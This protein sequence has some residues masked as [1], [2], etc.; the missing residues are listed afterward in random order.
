MTL[1]ESN[2]KVY[3]PLLLFL[4]LSGVIFNYALTTSSHAQIT[5][6][7]SLGAGGPVASGTL[8][9]G[10]FTDYLIT[11][12]LGKQVGSNL[13]HSFGK[14]SIETGKSGTFTG[15]GT[16]NN[17]IGRVTGGE[18]SNIDGVLRSTID[19]ANLFLLNPAG[20]LF[21]PNASL[22]I[23]GS[24]HVSTA[25]YIRLGEDGIVHADISKESLLTIAPPSAFGFLS[26][27]PASITIE[28]SKLIVPEDTILSVVGGDVQVEGA[29]LE[30]PSGQINLASVASMGEVPVNLS[31]L[32]MDTVNSLGEVM[33]SDALIQASGNGGG[34]VV[35]R[36][37]QLIIDDS[38]VF[39]DTEGNMDGAPTGIDVQVAE[40]VVLTN[41]TYVTTDVLGAGDAGNIQVTANSVEVSNSTT[42]GS[43]AISGSSG[44]AG[45]M[46]ITA[47]EVT[48]SDSY[49]STY[50]SGQ[51]NAGA[52][53]MEVDRLKLTDSAQ[54][55]TNA[56]SSSSG[57]AGPITVTAR[58][59]ITIDGYYSGLY[60]DTSSVGNAGAINLNTDRLTLTDGARIRSAAYRV[61]STGD[62][63]PITIKATEEVAASGSYISAYTSGHGDAGAINLDTGRLTLTDGARI[64]SDAYRGST[65]QAGP[66]TVTAREAINIDGIYSGLN[67]ATSS[68]RNGGAINLETKR[69]TLTDRAEII[70][71][72]YRGSKGHAGPITITATEEVAAGG[73]YISAYTFGQGDAGAINLDVD[74]LKLTGGAQI[75]TNA[76]SSS[77]GQA[78]AISVTAREAIN[79][80]GSSS[81]LYTSTYS[82]GNAGAINLD[83]RKLT[84]T[85][86]ARID[87]RAY[88][89]STGHA[90]PITITAK[91]VTTSDSYISA[92]TRSQG[93]AG[94]I[95]LKVDRLFLTNDGEISAGIYYTGTGRGGTVRVMA[96][97]SINLDGRFTL[98]TVGARGTGA[99]GSP[100]EVIM[101]A[102]RITITGG[103][104]IGNSLVE[105]GGTLRVTAT[106]TLTISDSKGGSASG[107]FSQAFSSRAG[108]DIDVHVGRLLLTN[109]GKISTKVSPFDT[110]GNGG[111]ITIIA[112]DTVTISDGYV[113]AD[114]GWESSGDGG[115]IVLFAPTLEVANYG[116]IAAGTFG[117]GNA[118]SI[119]IQ[120]DRLTLTG[121]GQI[122][123]TTGRSSDG[124]GGRIKVTAT[125]SMI[126]DGQLQSEN[127]P[128]PWLFR[129]RPSGILSEARSKGDAGSIEVHVGKLTLSNG[130][131]ISATSD[132]G[133]TGQGGTVTVTATDTVTI[134]GQGADPLI[135]G[136]EDRGRPL[137]GLFSI[138]KGSK[139]AGQILLSA[140]TVELADLGAIQAFTTGDGNAGTI[141]MQVGWLTVTSGGQITS[142]AQIDSTGE[143]GSVM[144][145]ATDDASISGPGS[146]LFT[147]AAGSG[148]GGNI[149]LKS[150]NFELTDG[151]MVS[152]KSSEGGNAGNI[153]ITAVK[154]IYLSN[155]SSINTEAKQADG[156][157]IELT[158]QS[159][160]HLQNSEITASVGGGPD[161]IG[162]NITI[163]PEFVILDNSQII[164]NAFEG[165]GGNIQITAGVFM[166]DPN[167]VMSASSEYG[168]SGEVDIKAPI[169]NISGSLTP[170]EKNYLSA[171]S[172][173]RQPCAARV[174]GGKYSSFV[175][176]GRD[177]LP[178][179]PGSFMPSPLYISKEAEDEPS[180]TGVNP[181]DMPLIRDSFFESDDKTISLESKLNEDEEMLMSMCRKER[182]RHH[183]Q[184]Q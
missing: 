109:G 67:A 132:I 82:V 126:I 173:L 91:E 153:D 119:D 145:T 94:D 53:E 63:G 56:F 118:G 178:L 169:S 140:P 142:S 116:H 95:N 35:I 43:R 106:D 33:V 15:P 114:S 72:A 61:S 52:I 179:E 151:A 8:S 144:V 135:F 102:K 93:N 30:A 75:Y 77:S 170:S 98:I 46:T 127:A 36:G 123:T 4:F 115:R 129:G 174:S 10:T 69:L 79:I 184:T 111:T 17:V 55:Y 13:F 139:N 163:D 120:V 181:E 147:E 50:T 134:V 176:G 31:D 122:V 172:L 108:G 148:T 152:A 11:S 154:G 158:A 166:A 103:A 117:I 171:A 133:S 146:G 6:D 26:G 112:S 27:N 161:T 149:V 168:I 143:G 104:Q 110:T 47:T 182:G 150:Q 84:L 58:E 2:R 90:G 20:V 44:N 113:D 121:G 87:S 40:D 38:Y 57:Q 1:T 131:Q 71:A 86:S 3:I 156:G 80:E 24:F 59:A 64:R 39:A 136:G 60:T 160:V 175:V 97:D 37:G 62:A 29:T 107:L 125:D 28:E 89:Y 183:G 73:S 48:A 7:G 155:D 78:G 88:R 137:S 25:D 159:M 85:D 51:G 99:I 164:A 65:G 12:D 68:V 180:L 45:R 14:F 49:I 16:I 92:Y 81:G 74:R 9:D 124:Q 32:K 165:K 83:T 167:S 162:G 128:L 141:E 66:I 157:N 23:K 41:E 5:L 138:T 18:M 101:E 177:G 42:L 70:S 100:G 34:T 76:F 54:I 105:S 96:T 22:D 19:S 130:G 21:G